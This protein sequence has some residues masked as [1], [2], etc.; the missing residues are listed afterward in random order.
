MTIEADNTIAIT[1]FSCKSQSATSTNTP[2]AETVSL[3]RGLKGSGL[4]ALDFWET[5]LQRSLVL[6]LH[7]DNES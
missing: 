5:V 7:E 4:P 2:E 6:Q 1:G 3:E